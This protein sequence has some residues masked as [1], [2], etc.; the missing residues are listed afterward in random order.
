MLPIA[1]SNLAKS[2]ALKT[3]MTIIIIVILLLIAWKLYQKAKKSIDEAI[4]KK[5]NQQALNSLNNTNSQDVGG[6]I[7]S[8]AE[9]YT[10]LQYQDMA[11]KLF[12]AMDGMGT[13]EKK[14]LTTLAQ[15]KTKADWNKLKQAYGTR[16]ISAWGFGYTGTLLECLKSELSDMGEPDFNE[17]DVNAKLNVN[18]ILSRFGD[19]I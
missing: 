11:N 19:Q 13:D 5:K 4:Q 12:N 15:L 2:K 6:A 7:V 10:N 8:T 1:V 3:I 14:I 18:N 9:T 17:Y 16:K